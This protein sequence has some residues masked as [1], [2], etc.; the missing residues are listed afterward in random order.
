MFNRRRSSVSPQQ[1]YLSDRP[2]TSFPTSRRSEGQRHEENKTEDITQRTWDARNDNTPSK[3]SSNKKQRSSIVDEATVNGTD[4]LIKPN[5]NAPSPLSSASSRETSSRQSKMNNNK[6]RLQS[7]EIEQVSTGKEPALEMVVIKPV[8]QPDKHT[9]KTSGSTGG[10]LKKLN[11]FSFKSI[12]K[13]FFKTMTFQSDKVEKLYRRYFFRLNQSFVNRL[14]VVLIVVIGIEIGLHFTYHDNRQKALFYGYGVALCAIVLTFFVSAAI[15]NRSDTSGKL[16]VWTSYVI[17][18]LTCLCILLQLVF[19][20]E[21]AHSVTEGVALTMF[22]IYMNYTM[23]P[24][25]LWAALCGGCILA[26][27][28]IITSASS[29]SEESNLSHL[30]SD[31]C[32]LSP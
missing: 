13:T 8:T 9:S 23:L 11:P 27:T 5:K 21:H 18:V 10:F 28:H 15:I 7:V 22:F 6:I 4:P 24:I 26:A 2:P 14:L 29:A 25:R 31:A 3:N 19:L 30:V 1:D 17:I 32:Q 12:Q 20:R 16:L